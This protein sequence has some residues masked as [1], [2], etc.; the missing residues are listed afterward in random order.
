MRT[1]PPLSLQPRSSRALIAAI[2]AGYGLTAALV[3]SLS[4]PHALA[5]VA[6]VAGA[7]ARAMWRIAGPC[8]P[9]RIVVGLDRCIALTAR[10]GRTHR[11]TILADSYVT[12]GLTTIVWR[13]DG[14][15]FVRT[16]LVVSDM[17]CTDDLRRLRVVLRY[18]RSV[19]ARLPASGVDAG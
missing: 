6:F 16:L 12:A 1:A 11:G 7:A 8:A 2:A 5:L 19:A 9:A 18:G 3:A 14:A 4:L 10:N 13:P 15:R 17:L